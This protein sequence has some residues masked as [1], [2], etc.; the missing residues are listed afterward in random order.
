MSNNKF[1]LKE[2]INIINSGQGTFTS[3]Y[4]FIKYITKY[5]EYNVY[6]LAIYISN[7]LKDF[8]WH[9][10]LLYYDDDVLYF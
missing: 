4:L 3:P 7:I 6:E 8:D 5:K 9:P 1:N 2:E 10:K